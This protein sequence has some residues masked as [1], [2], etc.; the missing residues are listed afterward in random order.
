MSEVKYFVLCVT[1]RLGT[2]CFV[3]FF[4]IKNINFVKNF[5]GGQFIPGPLLSVRLVTL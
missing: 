3:F 1:V 2:L 5:L 4:N